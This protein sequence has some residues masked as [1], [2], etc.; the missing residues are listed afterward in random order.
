[1]PDQ[2][3]S[4]GELK[5][6]IE[7][8]E[9]GSLDR[10]LV[11]VPVLIGMRIGEVLGLAWPAID[12]KA[13]KLNVRLNLV[14]S[15][16]GADVQLRTPKSTKSRRILDIPRELAHELRLWKLK[17]PPSEDDLVNLSARDS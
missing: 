17:N 14:V 8:T 12:F 10:I 2:V 15:D 5:S 13:N 7:A 11:M 1:M 16:N 4:E 9:Q 3:Y 6:L